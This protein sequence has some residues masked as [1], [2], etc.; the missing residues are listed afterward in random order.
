MLLIWMMSTVALLNKADTLRGEAEELLS[1]VSRFN[2]TVLTDLCSLRENGLEG[3]S[4]SVSRFF[5]GEEFLSWDA[6]S[7]ESSLAKLVKALS[8]YTNTKAAVTSGHTHGPRL[9]SCSLEEGEG[10]VSMAKVMALIESHAGSVDADGTKASDGSDGGGGD[11][12]IAGDN[13]KP[14]LLR[15]KGIA[16]TGGIGAQS[17]FALVQGAFRNVQVENIQPAQARVWKLR[18]RTQL[19]FIGVGF[20]RKKVATTLARELRKCVVHAH[21]GPAKSERKVDVLRIV[22]GR[23]TSVMRSVSTSGSVRARFAAAA[24]NEAKSR[25]FKGK[26]KPKARARVQAVLRQQSGLK[27][28][29]TD[30]MFLDQF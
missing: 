30:L 27:L 18:P 16:W 11:G 24:S 28:S 17:S 26:S 9:G 19:V 8:V 20:G 4:S 3:L 13:V 15:C 1:M 7:L 22:Q 2:P 10:P 14:R 6:L 23:Q 29:S 12:D 5:S 21:G 25:S